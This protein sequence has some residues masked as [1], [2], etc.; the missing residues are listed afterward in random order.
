MQTDTQSVSIRSVKVVNQNL[1]GHLAKAAS[2]VSDGQASVP[3]K[4]NVNQAAGLKPGGV[5][6]GHEQEEEEQQQRQA[7]SALQLVLKHQL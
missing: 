2:V 4:L 3:A 6:G 7:T 5:S 1:P